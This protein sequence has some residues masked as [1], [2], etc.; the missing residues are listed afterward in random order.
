VAIDSAGDVIAAGRIVDDP[1]HLD[2]ADHHHA[3]VVKLAG[4]RTARSCGGT[5][6]TAARPRLAKSHSPSN[7]THWA[8][9]SPSP[10]CPAA[11][12]RPYGRWS[13]WTERPGRSSGATSLPTPASRRRRPPA[14]WSS[15]PPATWRW[16]S[17][18][19]RS[20]SPTTPSSCSPVRMVPSAGVTRRMAHRT[21]LSAPFLS[22]RSRS[23]GT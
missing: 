4:A 17:R 16:D 15:S 8:M 9:P 13:S 12:G 10:N 21:P 1:A 3:A 23:R 7:S 6:S 14:S 19:R 22:L 18:F 2:D 11:T 20:G 5:R